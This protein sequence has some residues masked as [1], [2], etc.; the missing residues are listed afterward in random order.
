MKA[1]QATF[2]PDRRAYL[3]ITLGVLLIGTGPMFV[4]YVN[5]NGALVAF[6]R[7]LFAA[8]MLTIPAMRQKPAPAAGYSKKDQFLWAVLGGLSFAVNMTLWTMAL[9]LATASTVTLLD[10][11]APVWV[12]LFTW[13][14]LGKKQT[15]QYWLGLALALAGAFLLIASDGNAFSG[16]GACGSVLAILAGITYAWYLLVSKK[17]RA[18]MPS[19]RY[20]WLVALFAAIFLFLYTLA[21]GV[22]KEILPLKSYFLIFLLALI[23]QVV[24][25]YFINDALGK[26]PATASSVALVGQPLVTTILG[27]F[28]LS[29]IPTAWQILGGLACL[30]GIVIVQRSFNNGKITKQ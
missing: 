10:N 6:Y 5:A 21:T 25:W 7:V 30:A 2:N 28:I 11:T 1:K 9:N 12:G 23:S 27:I 22:I 29:E 26:L 19:L 13:L 4:K 14:V 17:C 20:T 24:G 15:G 18:M 8:V 16:D 3:R